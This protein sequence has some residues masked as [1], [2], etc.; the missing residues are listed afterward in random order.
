ML[1]PSIQFKLYYPF[2]YKVNSMKYPPDDEV[3]TFLSDS[4]GIPFD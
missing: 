2:V 3:E 4:L 1:L